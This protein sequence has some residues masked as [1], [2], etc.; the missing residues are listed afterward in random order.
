MVHNIVDTML[1]RISPS[2]I[3]SRRFQLSNN[4]NN[5]ILYFQNS[6]VSSTDKHFPNSSRSGIAVLDHPFN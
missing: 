6:Q 4:N 3:Y 2:M 1:E 5:N